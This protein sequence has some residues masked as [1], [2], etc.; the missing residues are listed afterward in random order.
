LKEA[1]V[2][3]L[4]TLVRDSAENAMPV[5][6]ED[7]QKWGRLGN[8]LQ[9]QVAVLRKEMAEADQMEKVEEP[10]EKGQSDPLS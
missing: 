8:L 3:S 1:Y 4:L 5:E 2:S 9:K 7:D 10:A 6:D